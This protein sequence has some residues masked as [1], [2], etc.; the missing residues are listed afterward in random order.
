[1]NQQYNITEAYMQCKNNPTHLL[2]TVCQFNI[3]TTT[4]LKPALIPTV[5]PQLNFEPRML[6]KIK[7][8]HCAQ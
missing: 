1:M 3:S 5:T 8:T 4:D 7:L 2:C 6:L